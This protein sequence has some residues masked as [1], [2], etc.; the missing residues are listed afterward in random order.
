[1]QFVLKKTFEMDENTSDRQLPE[2][3]GIRRSPPC[4]KYVL[5]HDSK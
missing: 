3:L 5:F 1:M 4:R 2:R